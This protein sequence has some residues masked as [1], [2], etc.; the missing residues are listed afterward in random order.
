MKAKEVGQKVKVATSRRK[1]IKGLGSGALVTAAATTFSSIGCSTQRAAAE[2]SS[3]FD[4][5]C[6]GSGIGGCSAAIAGHDKGFKTLLLEKAN[7]VGGT[8]SQSGG[9][10]WAPMNYLMNA[11]GINDSRDDAIS[12]LRYTG[13]GY[14]VP[15]YME[16]FVD[17]AHRVVEYLHQ[18]ADVNFRLIDLSEFYYPVSPGSKK[19]GRLI[20]CEPFPAETLGDWRS[21]VWVSHFH[22]GLSE[23]LQG[24]EHNPALGGSDGPSVG[25]SGPVRGVDSIALQLW[26]KRL[27]PKLEPLLK[28]DEEHRVAGAALAAYLF[29]AVLKRGI[30]VRTETAAETLLAENG[31]VVGVTVNNQGKQENIRATKGVLLA[32]GVNSPGWRLASPV[33]GA[34]SSVANLQGQLSIH[35]PTEKY[36]EGSRGSRGGGNYEFRMRHGLIVNRFAERYGD[37]SFFEKLGSQICHFDTWGEHRF[38]NIPSYFIFAQNLLEK[39]SFCGRPPGATEG[40]EWVAQGNTLAE[41]ARKLKIPEAKLEATVARFNEHARRGKDL[42]FDRNPQTLGPLE[43]P[44]FYGL[45]LKTPDPLRADSTGVSINP[46]GQVVQYATEKPI[47]GLYACGT[48]V[49]REPF[50]GIGYQAGFDLME[51]ATLGFL[52]A[53]HAARANT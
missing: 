51:S 45:E 5:I 42:D 26:R 8:T 48:M 20:I 27:G 33:G 13:A 49:A 52:A 28:K 23:A 19:H 16:A 46:Q 39:Y 29:R 21:R 11:A 17:N 7:V 32:T 1:F 3:T 31:R 2:W 36:P 30:Q 14:S 25:H 53:E 37:E 22:H 41:V 6:V 34:V 40:L 9:I 44:P 35:V 38:R 24:Q 18:K 4:W 12:Y 10:L 15:E 47:P 50:W 43:K